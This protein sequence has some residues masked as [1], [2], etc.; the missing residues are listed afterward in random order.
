MFEKCT[1]TD[2]AII[3]GNPDGAL[4][5]SEERIVGISSETFSK[6]TLWVSTEPEHSSREAERMIGCDVLCE[7]TC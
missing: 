2:R 4:I 1:P 5:D 6:K 3:L 7:E